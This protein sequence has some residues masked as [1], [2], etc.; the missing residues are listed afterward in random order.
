MKKLGIESIKIIILF[1]LSLGNELGKALE[2]KKLSIGEAFGF[3][4]DL[5]DIDDVIEAVKKAPAEFL[6]LDS[7]EKAEIQSIVKVEFDIEDD[8]VEDAIE[9]SFGFTLDTFRY[10]N[11]MRKI[12]TPKKAA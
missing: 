6:D 8:K 2:D 1:G 9:E 5:N 3:I 12:F 4:D 10:V 11:R 7:E